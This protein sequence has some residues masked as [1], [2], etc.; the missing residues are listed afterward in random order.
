VLS[1]IDPPRATAHRGN[2]P[3]MATLS[4]QPSVRRFILRF[5]DR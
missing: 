4:G 1:F 3:I 5:A 2:E